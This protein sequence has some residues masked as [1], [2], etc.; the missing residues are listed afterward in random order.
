MQDLTIKQIVRD[1]DV[2]RAHTHNKCKR[3]LKKLAIK[4]DLFILIIFSK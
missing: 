1:A 4:V 3:F 2:Q